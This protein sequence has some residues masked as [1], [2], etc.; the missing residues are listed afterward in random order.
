MFLLF[1]QQDS[2][3]VFVVVLAAML[4]TRAHVQPH[5]IAPPNYYLARTKQ[6]VVCHQT[7]PVYA[8]GRQRQTRLSV[9]LTL[10]SYYILLILIIDIK[11]VF[12]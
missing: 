3:K 5:P 4:S 12:A 6:V 11:H 10:S 2:E 1:C 8:K 9:S 7:L